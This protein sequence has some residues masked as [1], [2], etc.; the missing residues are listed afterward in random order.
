MTNRCHHTLGLLSLAIALTACGTS[1]PAD[2]GDA[3]TIMLEDSGA[4]TCNGPG[5]PYGTSMGRNFR[6]FTLNRCDGTSFSFYGS[7]GGYCESTFTVLTMAA[8]WCGPCIVESQ[9]L[10]A[11]IVDGY[12]DR[13]VRVV[14]VLIQDENYEAPSAEFCQG[15]VDR[16]GLSNPVVMD[17]TQI[18]QIYFPAGSL[19]ATLIVDREGVIRHREYGTSTGLRTITAALDALLASE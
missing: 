9:Q 11:E 12:A 1:P 18:T 16:F 14:Q 4:D 5:E 10:E 13:G 6:P 8:G 7:E 2:D 17:P 19:P 15:W 3:G